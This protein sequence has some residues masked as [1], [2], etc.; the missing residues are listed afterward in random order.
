MNEWINFGKSFFL[1]TFADKK[2]PSHIWKNSTEQLQHML[3]YSRS[4]ESLLSS[5]QQIDDDWMSSNTS[6]AKT[7]SAAAYVYRYVYT[8][9]LGYAMTPQRFRYRSERLHEPEQRLRDLDSNVVN[10]HRKLQQHMGKCLEV[11]VHS[12][13][14]SFRLISHSAPIFPYEFMHCGYRLLKESHFLCCL[15]L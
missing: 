11:D 5:T 8:T 1:H 9:T 2:C 10:F 14:A 4:D 3:N 12:V 6:R 7:Q 13:W 15:M